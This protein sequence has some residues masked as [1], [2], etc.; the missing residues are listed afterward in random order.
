PIDLSGYFVGDLN[1]GGKSGTIKYKFNGL[2]SGD[3]KVQVRAW[4]IFNNSSESEEHFTVV[5]GSDMAIRDV[6]N[7]PNPFSSSTTF[8]FQRNT[9]DPVD[10]KIR[11][12]TVAGR[13]IKEM[14][15][16]AVTDKFVRIDWD[17]RDNDGNLLSNG[18]YLYKVSIKGAQEAS[19]QEVLGK[20]AVIR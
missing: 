12:Y 8:T 18:V 20:L 13:M 16:M 2:E 15:T 5:G 17:G 9:S 6:L 19:R 3:Y 4:D 11:V 7:Y 10:V 1:A 14:E